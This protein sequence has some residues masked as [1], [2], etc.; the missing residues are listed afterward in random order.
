MFYTVGTAFNLGKHRSSYT[1][2]FGADPDKIAAAGAIIAKDL[3]EMQHDPVSAADLARAKGILLR[4]IPLGESSFDAIGG[5]LLEL[6]TED[7]PLDELTIAGRQYLQ[8]T[9]TQVEDAYAHHIRPE[10]FV[11]AVKGPAPK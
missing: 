2:S 4:Q 11:T 5:Q 8:M 7:K 1:V 10:G 3:A 6:S 9:A